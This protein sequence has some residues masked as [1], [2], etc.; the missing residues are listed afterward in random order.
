M[1]ALKR[2]GDVTSIAKI[3]YGLLL[4]G[5]CLVLWDTP[6]EENEASGTV[7]KKKQQVEATK[8]KE[9]AHV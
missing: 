3:F 4:G 8:E 2:A 9:A 6:A 5:V 1:R 7:N